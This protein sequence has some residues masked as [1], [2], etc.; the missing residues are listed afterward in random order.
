MINRRHFLKSIMAASL[1]PHFDVFSSDQNK[2]KLYDISLSQWSFH[3]AIFGESRAD[4]N[5]FIKTLHSEPDLVLKG[6]IDPRYITSI[7]KKLDI[8]KVDL[9]NTLW[10]GHATDKP[11]LNEFK[12]RANND[13]VTFK[14]LMCDEMGSIGS[15]NKILR[16]QAI[17][18]HLPWF[19]A[20]AELGCSQL[21]VNAYGDG[22]Y[23]EQLKQNA[24]SLQVL[25]EIGQEYGLE[26]LVENHGNASN[27][28]AWLA[29]LMEMT[30]HSNVGVFTDLDNFFMGGWSL[31]PERLYDRTQGIIDLAPY[32]RGVSAKTH[33]FTKSGQEST[34]NYQKLLSI[35]VGQG[36]KGTVSAEYEGEHMS[37]YDGSSATIKLLKSMQYSL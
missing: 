19:E 21:R 31:S 13:G 22:T 8:S 11:W 4:Y 33:A 34:I 27:N 2:S 16:Q 32:T 17:N 18:N 37:E 5:A 24:E 29:M 6:E 12:S 14:L 28:G 20:A 25:G 10:F 36:F 30:I 7:A 26:V 15:S 35:I 1:I 9:A 23:L 3:R